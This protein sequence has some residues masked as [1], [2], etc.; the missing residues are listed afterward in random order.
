MARGDKWNPFADEDRDDMDIEFI[1]L[2]G[3]EERRGSFALF[4]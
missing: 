1:D 2:A 3:V 4:S